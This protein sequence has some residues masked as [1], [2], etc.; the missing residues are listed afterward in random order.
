MSDELI[1]GFPVLRHEG[2]DFLDSVVYTVEATQYQNDRKL[3]ITHTLKGN[4]FIA[5]LL[6]S[7]KAAFL[8]SFFYKDNAERQNFICD[9]WDYSEDKNEIIAEQSIDIDFSYAPEINPCIVVVENETIIVNDHSGLTEFWQDEKFD[10]P[11]FSR[12]AYHLKLQFTSGNVSS[13]LNVQCDEG[14]QS[15]SIKPKVIETAGEGDQP[16]KII[17]AQDVFDELKNQVKSEPFDA[18][19]AMRK[20]IITQVLCHVYA[21][22]NNLESKKEVHSGLLKH[23]EMVF[24][25]TGENWKDGN[26]FNASFAATKITPYAI[27]AL[28]RENR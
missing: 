8:V 22:M 14:Y 2:G 6:K 16:I 7:K 18:Q 13:L 19:T 1:L 10:V 25:Q 24:N 15:G 5:E 3:L 23:M 17:C 28:N 12:V 9:D 27:D 20:A 4:S 11:A 26:N 21:H